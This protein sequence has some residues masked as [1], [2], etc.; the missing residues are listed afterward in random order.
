MN[1]IEI[2]NKAGKIKLNDIVHQPVIDRL[3]SEIGSIF[4]AS[5]AA[6][7]DYSGELMNVAEN[8]VDTLD[9]EIHTPGGSVFEGY[10]LYT[11]IKEMQARGVHVT[12]TINSLAASMGS[13]I[14]M[15]CDVIRMVP[16]GR[17][18]IHDVQTGVRGNAA[19]LAKAAQQ[20]DEMSNDIAQVY[21]DRTG[22]KIEDIREKMKAETWMSAK[23]AL[24]DG[25]IDQIYAPTAAKNAVD[26]ASVETTPRDMS[27]LD[28]LT[29]PSDTEAQ[30]RII[31]L[32]ATIS[33]HD[34]VVSDYEAKLGIAETALAEIEVVKA[35]NLTLSAQV[36]TIADLQA[37]IAQLT[38]KAEI[39]E[40]KI[41]E[42]A[43]QMLAAQGHGAPLVIA[44]ENLTQSEAQGDILDQYEA[45]SGQEK[46][47]FLAKHAIEIQSAAKSRDKA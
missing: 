8:A 20:C 47:D 37:S 45:M 11:A 1:L 38:E 28:R 42:A 15:A 32:E 35:E 9:I 22:H 24:A 31:A 46:R 21:A 43:A 4:G 12:G 34:Q 5:A 30:E 19:D 17:M 36:A 41:G 39:T 16:G 10:R 27:F 40:T 25:F 2:E 29:N 13:V 3:I 23:A 26:I 14:A 7:G 33:Q 44:G 18:M 6:S